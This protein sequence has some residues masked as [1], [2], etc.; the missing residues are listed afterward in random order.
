VRKSNLTKTMAIL[1]LAG[2]L[3]A[4]H[5]EAA[6]GIP[7]SA[8]EIRPLLIGATVPDV[9]LRTGQGTET[10]LYGAL[11]EQPAVLIVYRGG[12]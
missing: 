1:L 5:A 10:T 7:S 11:G 8:E 3:T 6:D 4:G 2:A 12:W 9:A